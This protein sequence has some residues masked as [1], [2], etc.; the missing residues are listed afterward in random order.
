MLSSPRFSARP[1]LAGS[2]R[3]LRR[4]QPRLPL[5]SVRPRN[6]GC[7][8]LFWP[9]DILPFHVR[10]S[11]EGHQGPSLFFSSHVI[12]FPRPIDLAVRNGFPLCAWFW[13]IFVMMAWFYLFLFFFS[14]STS[15]GWRLVVG[16][17]WGNC[18]VHLFVHIGS[19]D[20]REI[21]VYLIRTGS[22]SLY[23][24]DCRHCGQFGVSQGQWNQYGRNL[25]SWFHDPAG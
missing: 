3:P 8:G 21:G 25:G 17:Q 13:D 18:F 1:S 23:D 24:V 6:R 22:L 20:V 19:H 15:E 9:N 12:S 2:P 14:A 5:R 11:R 4:R 16:S 10:S 7:F